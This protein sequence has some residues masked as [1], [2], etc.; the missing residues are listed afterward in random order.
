[1]PYHAFATVMCE[2]LATDDRYTV[3]HPYYF[4]ADQY[5]L[6]PNYDLQILSDYLRMLTERYIAAP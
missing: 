4:E 3:K 2:N 6:W 5:L 1:M